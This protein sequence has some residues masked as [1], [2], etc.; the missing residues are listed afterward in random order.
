MKTKRVLS[1]ILS[2]ILCVSLLAGC[3][4]KEQT[5][6]DISVG[7]LKGPTAIG[8]VRLM[9]QNEAKSASNNYNFTIAGTADELSAALIKGDMQLAAVPCNLASVL[10]NKTEGKLQMLAINTLGVLYI[11]EAGNTIQSVSDLKGKTIYSTGKGTTPEFTLRHLL[12]SAGID[13]D[14][15]VTIEYKSEATEIASLLNG[16]TEGI[17]MLPQPYVTTVT[18]NNSNLRIALNVTEEWEKLDSGS[19]VV[20]GVIVGNKDFIE[21]NPAAVKTFLEEYRISTAY[22]NENIDETANLVEHFDIFK[23]AVAKKAIPY[24]NIVCLTGDEMQAKAAS[25][26]QVLFDGQS[27]SVGGKLP[28]DGFYYKQK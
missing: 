4:K 21:Q 16:A 10:Y 12:K 18:M 19:T 3:G 1:L 17:A 7:V 27:T 22:A 24:C 23:A 2:G 25:Y 26:L 11:V 8:M 28:D 13:P 15:D 6:V 5:P 9:E 14:K 20:T